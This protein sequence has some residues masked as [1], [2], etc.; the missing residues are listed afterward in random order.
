M[1]IAV[2]FYWLHEHFVYKYAHSR[3][4]QYAHNEQHKHSDLKQISID[5]VY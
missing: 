1:Y 5:F 3:A 2:Y 4:L